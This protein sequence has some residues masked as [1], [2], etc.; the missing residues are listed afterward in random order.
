MKAAGH[1]ARKAIPALVEAP[2][3]PEIRVRANARTPW[4]GSIPYRPRI[5]GSN[6]FFG[7]VTDDANGRLRMKEDE[8][9]Q[10]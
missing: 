7:S 8:R 3:R 4:P 1:S 6:F 10:Y 2:E 5:P 9:D